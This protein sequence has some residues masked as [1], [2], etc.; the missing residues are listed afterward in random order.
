MKKKLSFLVA[1][2][3]LTILI[4]AQG[5]GIGI[6]T[7]AASSMLDITSTTK[8][9]LIPR[10]TSQQR[11]AIANPVI[12][13]LVFDTD[14]KTV[15][16]Y[17]GII[18]K[19]LFTNGGG[20]TLPYAQS[21]S[22]ASTAFH[23]TNQGIGPA[24]EGSSSAEF[25][26]GLT[27]KTTGVGG[28]GLYAF[29]NGQGAKSINAFAENGTAFH[30]ENNNAANTN[31]LLSLINK[32]AGKTSTF[33]LVN[34]SSTSV[35]VQIA[36]N[37]LG[38]QLKIF[39]T[40]VANAAP[41]LSIVNSGT[42][43]GIHAVSG[44]GP[45]MVGLSAANSGVRG[46]TSTGNSGAAGVYGENNGTQGNGVLGV[47][48]FASGFG[49]K[50]ESNFG[51]GVFGYSGNLRGVY[52]STISGTA[53]YANGGSGYALET[54]GNIKISGGNTNPSNGAVLTSDAAGNAV[55]KT[56]R[57]AFGAEGV[58]GNFQSV[59]NN[60]WRRVHFAPVGYYDYGNNFTLLIGANV[61]PTS[62]CFIAPINGS[63]H[64]DAAAYLSVFY[65]ADPTNIGSGDLVLKLNR[66][67][68]VSN[69]AYD[70]NG[71]IFKHEAGNASIQLSIAR[72]LFL[73]AGDIVYLEVRHV[74]DQGRALFLGDN[75]NTYFT[76]HLVAQ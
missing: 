37:S 46:I 53:I 50:G 71:V 38:E 17:D 73:M 24:L 60:V 2:Q 66:N 35:N 12:G 49:V 42:G 3:L 58:N 30:G 75:T 63:Y 68:A 39:Q 55:W 5:I 8:G 4:Y 20:L 48:N 67:G 23:V 9:L 27:A 62:S 16:A 34:N 6:G 19:N 69:L 41:A 15:W 29:S 52:G 36:G 47:A 65:L 59:P 76:G 44:T 51:T 31:T 43:D 54:L 32:G 57:L 10:M 13:L 70:G 45:G 33:Q 14:T 56:N 74:N 18:W 72:D 1:F 22:S 25:G 40:N 28:W 64:F 21:V 7:P 61:Q 26:T 11:G